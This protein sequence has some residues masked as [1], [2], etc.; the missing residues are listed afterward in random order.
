M[1][2]AI[3]LFFWII[4]FILNAEKYVERGNPVIYLYTYNP[5]D[6]FIYYTIPWVLVSL[7]TMPFAYGFP[8]VLSHATVVSLWLVIPSH[9]I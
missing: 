8:V 1:P 6:N 3:T 2:Y 5:L 9:L 7:Q 4:Y